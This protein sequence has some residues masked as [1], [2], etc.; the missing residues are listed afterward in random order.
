M[1]S[2][3]SKEKN[4]IIGC[5]H[6]LWGTLAISFLGLLYNLGHEDLTLWDEAF[7]AIAARN[8]LKHPFLPTLYEHAWLPYDYKDWTQSQVWFNKPPLALWQIALSYA[9]FGVNTFALRLPSAILATAAVYL[10]YKIAAEL[11]DR[12]TGII[13]AIFQGF[14][15][16]IYQLVYGYHFADHVDIALLFWV[17]LGF[18]LL[19]RATREKRPL[20]FFIT[21]VATGLGF[22]AKR[23]LALAVLALALVIWLAF[24]LGWTKL[25]GREIYFRDICLVMLGALITVAP[26]ALFCLIYYPMEYIYVHDITLAHLHSDVE[27][28]SA[29]WDRTL[30]DYMPMLYVGIYCL[31]LLSFLSFIFN[32]RCFA[33]FFILAWVVIT[34]TPHVYSVT[35]TPS[36]TLIA[37][38]ALLTMLALVLRRSWQK[39]DWLY[40]SIFLSSVCSISLLTEKSEKVLKPPLFLDKFAPFVEKNYWIVSQMGLALLLLCLLFLLHVFLRRFSDIRQNIWK[41]LRICWLVIFLLILQP[42][43]SET[44]RI[45]MTKQNVA[46]YVQLAKRLNRELPNNA[47]IF[48]V[49]NDKEI[50]Y[51]LMYYADRSVY[52]TKNNKLFVSKADFVRNKK[53]V[54]SKGGIP[55]LLSLE[56]EQENL[57]PVLKGTIVTQ[58]KKIQPYFVY[59]II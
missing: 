56:K 27:G 36:A 22:L 1:A 5:R 38:P 34:V 41:A 29:T 40:T 6:V 44:L 33:N 42:Y 12:P 2:R 32:I 54:R 10:S 4:S 50:Q 14:N 53:L 17:E 46:S 35:K 21:G 18:F 51:L 58:K 52:N 37:V 24:K 7:H 28:W 30:F 59:E 25:E 11:F 57:S 39:N 48:F 26:W 16:F 43:F 9:L 15:P 31:V 13:V 49:S 8:I 47:V 45:I 3:F 23:Y 20:A 19:L 55:Y